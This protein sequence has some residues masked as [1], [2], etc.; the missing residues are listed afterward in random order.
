M[1][2]FI[3]VDASALKSFNYSE[4]LA[5]YFSTTGT[6]AG[7][8]A[9]TKGEYNANVSNFSSGSQMAFTYSE[10][11][12]DRMV[13]MNGK[14]MQYDMVAGG[15]NHS[16]SGTANTI[17]FGYKYSQTG[18]DQVD[19]V[20]RSE[21]YNLGHGLKIS[22]ID[23]TT[24]FDNGPTDNPFLN[25]MNDLR[26]HSS[27]ADSYIDDLY[28][29]FASKGQNFIGSRNADE[30]KGT[31]FNDK[32]DGGKGIDILEGAG[33]KDVFLFSKGDTGKTYDTADTILDFKRGEDRINLS[34][35]DAVAGKKGDQAFT[36]IGG[37][38]FSG[39]AGEL[40]VERVDGQTYVSGD[41]NG[42]KVA[43]FMIHLEG[44]VKI[45]ASDFIL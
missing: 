3:T 14:N 4:F 22:G 43:D 9:F 13:V 16:F 42:D 24:A 32:I 18:Y 29:L 30:Y 5:D 8:H 2:K 21:V 20:S 34:D 23:V 44:N 27:T 7:T 36:W 45:A 26:R 25:L 17:E 39:K 15:E 35:I 33:G 11:G 41:W 6:G 40:H 31:E 37:K 10:A 12:N 1:A 38:D 19:G 28:A